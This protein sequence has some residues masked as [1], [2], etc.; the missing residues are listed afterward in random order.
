MLKLPSKKLRTKTF[1]SPT[2]VLKTQLVDVFVQSSS[3]SI[4][5]YGFDLI[6]I[7]TIRLSTFQVLAL[8]PQPVKLSSS[9]FTTQM[10]ITL[11]NWLSIDI[12]S[13]QFLVVPVTDPL[14]VPILGNT[15]S[16]YRGTFLAT[17]DRIPIVAEHTTL[18]RD[19]QLVPA[20]FSLEAI[21]LLLLTLKCSTK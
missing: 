17:Q 10:D 7:I 9:R 15:T 11:S 16:T 8:T 12:D 2:S 18:H 6:L 21:I 19:I 1:L 5:Y 4:A 20:G 3:I 14:L 13:M